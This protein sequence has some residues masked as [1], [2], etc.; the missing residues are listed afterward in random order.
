MIHQRKSLSEKQTL[1]GAKEEEQKL[2]LPG[3]VF[4]YIPTPSQVTSLKRVT[5]SAII[6]LVIPSH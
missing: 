6:I 2:S 5:A 1:G 3:P 4:T